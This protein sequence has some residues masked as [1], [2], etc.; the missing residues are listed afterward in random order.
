MSLI[1][2]EFLLA[3]TVTITMVTVMFIIMQ[4]IRISLKNIGKYWMVWI[5]I[6][7]WGWILITLKIL[8]LFFLHFSCE[9]SQHP[10]NNLHRYSCFP[11]DESPWHLT[12]ANTFEFLST[13]EWTAITLAFPSFLTLRG[14]FICKI[15]NPSCLKPH[16]QLFN[17]SAPYVELPAGAGR[18]LDVMTTE[19]SD[20][21]I[22]TVVEGRY[23]TAASLT[24]WAG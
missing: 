2:G 23:Q 14:S 10:L 9:I 11:E 7:P 18:S 24:Y 4:S 13:S 22:T 15:A 21:L 12:I 19:R 3:A 5:F 1:W 17:R 6:V 16:I 20:C 8:W